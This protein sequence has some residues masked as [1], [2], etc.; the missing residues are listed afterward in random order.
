M[1]NLAGALYRFRR[2][3]R[4][5]EAYWGDRAGLALRLH[6]SRRPVG[7]SVV[8]NVQSSQNTF[9]FEEFVERRPQAANIGR[10]QSGGTEF[11]SGVRE[12]I[13]RRFR[14]GGDRTIR[15]IVQGRRCFRLGWLG[16]ERN[17][18]I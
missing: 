14:R 11:R 8:E 6:V 10:R 3:G 17:A 1:L 7:R 13:L 4:C 16:T 2:G 9:A 18:I 5:V 15:A 12:S